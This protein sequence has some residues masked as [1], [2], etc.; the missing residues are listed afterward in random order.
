MGATS[1]DVRFTRSAGAS[2]TWSP[3]LPAETNTVANCCGGRVDH[4]RQPSLLGER[5]D[6]ADHVA[7]RARAAAAGSAISARFPPRAAASALRLNRPDTGTTAH[8]S[9]PSTTATSVLNSRSSDTPSARAACFAEGLGAR[10]VRIGVDGVGHPVT[11]E[12]RS[13]ACRRWPRSQPMSLLTR[14]SR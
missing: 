5:R 14:R 8:T 9:L 4:D 13:C 1:P 7:G 2:S 10:V 11:H 6:A 3:R 12:Q